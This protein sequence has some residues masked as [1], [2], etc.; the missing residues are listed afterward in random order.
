MTCVTPST[1]GATRFGFTVGEKW[2]QAAAGSRFRRVLCDAM[3]SGHYDPRALVGVLGERTARS[4][5]RTALST[6]HTAPGYHP[7]VARTSRGHTVANYSEVRLI[8][9]ML[10]PVSLGGNYRT[11]GVGRKRCMNGPGGGSRCCT[12]PTTS[13]S[14]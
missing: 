13:R 3:D 9:G 5:L 14:P 2:E 11:P 6:K 10:G 7:N 8:R 4:A 12:P 1:R